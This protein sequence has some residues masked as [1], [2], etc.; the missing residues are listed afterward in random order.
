[1]CVKCK[2]NENTFRRAVMLY[3]FVMV[4]KKLLSDF[5]N[6]TLVYLATTM[7]YSIFAHQSESTGFRYMKRRRKKRPSQNE[8]KIHKMP[9]SHFTKSSSVHNG[10]WI[11]TTICENNGTKQY[12]QPKKR[13][14]SKYDFC[15]PGKIS[16]HLTHPIFY[17]LN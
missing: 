7:K 9:Q 12:G 17:R 15:K 5:V 13:G 10:D 2:W 8:T 14:L 11:V 16:T 6:G 1:M 3:N 4:S